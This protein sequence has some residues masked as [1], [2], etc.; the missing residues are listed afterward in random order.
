ME[1]ICIF[2]LLRP[3]SRTFFVLKVESDLRKKILHPWLKKFIKTSTLIKQKSFKKWYFTVSSSKLIELLFLQFFL[4]PFQMVNRYKD[5]NQNK[6][7][8][9][10]KNIWNCTNISEKCFYFYFFIYIFISPRFF[11]EWRRVS[12]KLTNQ[13]SLAQQY[14]YYPTIVML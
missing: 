10:Q 7:K 5:Q 4:D 2:L 3:L 9:R 6:R 1:C 12:K 11:S 8:N 13:L 14:Y